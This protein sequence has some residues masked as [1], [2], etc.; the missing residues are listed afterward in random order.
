MP[1]PPSQYARALRV[2]Q[3]LKNL[4][5][6]VPPVLGHVASVTTITQ[7]VGAV[8]SFSLCA[9]SAY[10]LNDWLDLR[11]DRQH[12]TKRFRPLASGRIPLSH[13]A[14]LIPVLLIAGILVA[15]LLPPAFLLT[16]GIYYGLTLAYSLGLKRMMMVD[17]I[18][19]ACLYGIRVVAGGAACG[20][21]LSDWL[22]FFCVCLF[23]C[24]AL[25]KRATELHDSVGLG[26]GDPPGRGYRATDLPMIES[27]AASA[28]FASVVVMLLYISSSDVA[29]M[30]GSPK[31]LWAVCVVLVY[32]IGRALLLT[33]RGE[34][35][36][37]P[38]VFAVTDRASL[39]CGVLVAAAFVIAL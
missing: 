11:S 37:D 18:A 19:L 2:H 8:I 3:W 23:L 6:F 29:V 16:V 4:L 1:A 25:I 17:V 32:W 35:H 15:L 12:P 38:V 22:L 28:G 33:H 13:G 14:A 34:M 20:V 5:I 24:L 36:D 31:A 30:Y 39:A 9:S 21:P 10:L 26:L 7:A 27:I